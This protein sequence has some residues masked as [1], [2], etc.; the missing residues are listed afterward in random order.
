MLIGIRNAL[1]FTELNGINSR[2]VDKSDTNKITKITNK[3]TRIQ[4][5]Y[6]FIVGDV[7]KPWWLHNPI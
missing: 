2:L 5:R 1:H 6:S 3:N 4:I 7:A